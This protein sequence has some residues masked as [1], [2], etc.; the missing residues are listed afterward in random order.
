MGL[1]QQ[2]SPVRYN[3]YY[4]SSGGNQLKSDFFMSNAETFTMVAGA[5]IG[6]QLESECIICVDQGGDGDYYGFRDVVPV[7]DLIPLANKGAINL[8]VLPLE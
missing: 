2:A 3:V 1:F 8:Y 6:I 4:W 7:E 5:T